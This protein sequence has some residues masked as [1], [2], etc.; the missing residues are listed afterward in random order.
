MFFQNKLVFLLIIFVI[1]WFYWFQ[2]RPSKIRSSCDNWIKDL[3]GAVE[4]NF[5]SERAR[6]K[7]KA[8]YDRCLHEKGLK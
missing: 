5:S 2:Y 1:V 8:L 6:A 4:N 3:P 7:Y